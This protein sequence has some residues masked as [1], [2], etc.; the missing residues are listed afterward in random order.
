MPID[1]DGAFLLVQ[2][3]QAHWYKNYNYKTS[4]SQG[5]SREAT[6]TLRF[7]VDSGR[8]LG[9]RV[10]FL[11]GHLA[12]RPQVQTRGVRRATDLRTARHLRIACT[13]VSNDA[14]ASQSGFR[15]K[16]IVGSGRAAVSGLCFKAS[17]R[18][19]TLGL[20]CFHRRQ[21]FH[22]NRLHG[23]QCLLKHIANAHIPAG[24]CS[25]FPDIAE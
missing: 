20:P 19:S 24:G 5:L 15:S 14:L 25:N 10:G 11:P 22:E 7:S 16:A 17:V 8:T 21:G 23:W 1:R 12:V 3:C 4:G 6:A 9:Y 18:T 13:P 2:F